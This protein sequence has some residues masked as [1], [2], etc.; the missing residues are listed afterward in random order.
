MASTRTA[1]ARVHGTLYMHGQYVRG[2][3]CE[4]AIPLGARGS[5]Y[6]LYIGPVGQSWPRGAGSVGDSV[7]EGKINGTSGLMDECV[8]IYGYTNTYTY[9]CTCTY[10][11]AYTYT[12]TFPYPYP[13]PNPYPC[14]YAYAYT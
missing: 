3:A 7:G 8:F 14:T 1:S 9:T 12:C 11:Y 2:G 10:T 6:R 13:Y 5:V 4:G